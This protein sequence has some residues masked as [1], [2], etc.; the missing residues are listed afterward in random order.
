MH[1]TDEVGVAGVQ[2]A[3]IAFG[4]FGHGGRIG[5]WFGFSLRELGVGS[6]RT[7]LDTLVLHPHPGYLF[8]V[9]EDAT[10]NYFAV[11]GIVC[12]CKPQ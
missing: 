9:F 5:F 7:R 11:Q 2:D 3:T 6:D 10:S 4:D 8:L 12:S 1:G